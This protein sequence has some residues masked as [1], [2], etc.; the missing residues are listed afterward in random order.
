MRQPERGHQG[1][2]GH[3]QMVYSAR[4]AL[5]IVQSINWEASDT[6]VSSLCLR[7]ST[8]TEEE[9]GDVARLYA[10][11]T[12]HLGPHFGFTVGSPAD[13]EDFHCVTLTNTRPSLA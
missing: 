8:T 11:L 5:E 7:I 12:Q 3:L 2:H 4:E 13:N 9:I 10:V 1:Q 6:L